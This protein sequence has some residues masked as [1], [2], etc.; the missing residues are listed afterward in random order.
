MTRGFYQTL[1]VIFLVLY[2]LWAAI[3]VL[4]IYV[5]HPGSIQFR[6]V[7]LL[8]GLF[9]QPVASVGLWHDKKWGCFPLARFAGDLCLH[10][11]WRG[12]WATYR[13]RLNG[14]PI[15]MCPSQKV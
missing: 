5:A 15:F 7:I 1:I 8:T 11:V 10:V 4:A 3:D 14:R 12:D 6:G 2:P 9:L 13:I